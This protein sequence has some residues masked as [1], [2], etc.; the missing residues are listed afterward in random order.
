[1]TARS[2]HDRSIKGSN[3]DRG[4]LYTAESC[5]SVC[6]SEIDCPEPSRR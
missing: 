3:L 4:E 6:V 5:R 1:M 2:G